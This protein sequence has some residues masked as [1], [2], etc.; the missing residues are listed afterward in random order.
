MSS[1]EYKPILS[2]SVAKIC[3][4]KNFNSCEVSALDSLT[5]V[6]EFYLEHLITLTKNFSQL[7]NRSRINFQDL[8]AAFKT[9]GIKWEEVEIS[10][11]ELLAV[12]KLPVPKSEK[13]ALPRPFQIR[14]LCLD[15]PK[16]I[17]A[18]IPP[19]LPSFPDEYTFKETPTFPQR[20]KDPSKIREVNAEQT[21]LVEENLKRLLFPK[22]QTNSSSKSNL[23]DDD[24]DLP[25]VNYAMSKFYHINKGSNLKSL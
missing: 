20:L 6:A 9:L 22:S 2:K 4:H 23:Q 13:P 3:Q 5:N 11:T 25:C 21:R 15:P 12:N 19:Q 24:N 1:E 7:G 14:N 10:A 17:P 18:Y 16:K 8:E